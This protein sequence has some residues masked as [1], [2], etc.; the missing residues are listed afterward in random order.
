MAA[1]AA[2]VTG[3]AGTPPQ[4]ASTAP[5]ASSAESPTSAAKVIDTADFA[6]RAQDEGWVPQIRNGNVIYCRNE[7]PIDSRLPERVCLNKTGVEQMMLAEEHQRENL[8]RGGSGCP[9]NTG[10]N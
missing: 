9:M 7:S 5:S 4:T 8:R 10:C 2:I 3:C 6:R 1:V